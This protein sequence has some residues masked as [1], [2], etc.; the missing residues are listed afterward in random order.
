M[1][2][3]AVRYLPILS[4]LSIDNADLIGRCSAS[5]TTDGFL[6]PCY[7]EKLDNASLPSKVRQIVGARFHDGWATGLSDV[8]EA[9]SG[10]P[11]ELS[12]DQGV[13]VALRSYVPEP[14]T[15]VSPESIY[16][17]VFNVRCPALLLAID[18]ANELTEDE[19]QNLRKRWAFV[20][21]GQRL[22]LSF[23]DP[24]DD[25]PRAD[26]KRLVKY[27]WKRTPHRFS[28]RST[29][30]VKELVRRSMDIACV[31]AG[32]Q[33]CEHRQ[34]FYFPSLD[35]P[36][37]SVSYTHVDGRNTH[38]AVTG[39]QS[40]GSGDRAIPFRYQLSPGFRVGFDENQV[41]WLT[42]RV[43]VR[44]TTED[45]TPYEGKAIGRRRKK[46]GS[47]WWNKEWFARL[48]G[49]VQA[50]SSDGKKIVVGNERQRVVV[51][52]RPLTWLC[53]VS[54]DYRAVERAG[55]FQQEI[56]QLRYIDNEDDEDS[57]DE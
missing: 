33:W 18:L 23:E 52:C 37:R 49:V 48:L 50:L 43:Y 51:D 20:K 38:V 35:K 7:A 8:T 11:R 17:N 25:L 10:V 6:I 26:S 29:D 46:I 3:R 14:V 54:I 31:D 44:V 45:G 24:P 40:Y 28:K 56:S 30:V 4:R 57:P 21:A 22:L 13:S 42:L 36:L 47:S 19:E 15:K 55:D 12:N 5:L 39:M 53:P 27:K 1:Q 32:L 41:C 9:L 34:L 2:S 16:A